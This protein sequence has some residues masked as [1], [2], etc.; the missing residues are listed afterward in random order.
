MDTALTE[1]GL[2]VLE[3]NCFNGCGFYEHDLAK[4]LPVVT[5]FVER[6]S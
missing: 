5:D 6:H 2:R 3:F 4:I 1:K